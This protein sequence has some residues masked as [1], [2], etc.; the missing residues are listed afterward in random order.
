MGAWAWA[1]L[2]LSL[3]LPRLPALGVGSEAA[4]TPAMSGLLS[5]H[6]FQP[7]WIHFLRAQQSEC[8]GITYTDAQ[9]A[10]KYGSACQAMG[11]GRSDSPTVPAPSTAGA[12]LRVGER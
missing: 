10:G 6:D 11:R 2:P 12:V 5:S 1:A 9:R 4:L 8:S 3:D 7:A